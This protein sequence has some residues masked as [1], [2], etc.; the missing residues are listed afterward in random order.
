MAQQIHNTPDNKTSKVNQMNKNSYFITS[1]NIKIPKLIYGTAWKKERTASLVEAALLAGFRG[2]D[3]ACQPKHYEEALVGEAISNAHKHGIMRE[4]LFLQTKFTPLNGQDPS[5]IPYNPKEPLDIQVAQSFETS[6]KNLQ[7]DYVDSLLLHSPLFPF[8]DLMRVWR[9]MERI[10]HSKGT[11]GLGIS[12][13]YDLKTLSR[14]Y[15]EAEI[16]PSVV[17][18]RFYLE[19]EYDKELRQWCDKVDIRYQGFWTLTA[20]PHILTSYDLIKIAQTY[21]KTEAQIFYR[22]LS[23]IGIIPLIGTTSQEHMRCDMDIFS[24]ELGATDIN[25]IE[26]LLGL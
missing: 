10:Y 5:K 20:N 6:K 21:G 23:H 8:E 24:F 15:E 3:T 4:D 7:T 26:A 25:S 22:F 13:C 16:K 12:N 17:Q 11:K 18:N 1:E 9:A 19:S 2:I 14:L